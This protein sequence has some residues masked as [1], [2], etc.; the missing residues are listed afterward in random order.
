MH[1]LFYSFKNFLNEYFPFEV[2]KLPIQT[3]LGCPHRNNKT[4]EGGCIYC[5]EPAFSNLSDSMPSIKEQI[6][7][8]LD[9]EQKRNYQGKFMAYFQTGTN[10]Y[11]DIHQLESYYKTIESYDSIV[12]LAVSTRPDC[13]SKDILQLLSDQAQKKM[14]WL[15]L[16]MQSAHDKTLRFINRGHDFKCFQQAVNETKKYPDILICSH[17]ILGLPGE[18]KSEMLQTIKQFNKLQLKGIKLHHLQIVKNTIMEKMYKKGKIEV[19]AKQDYMALLMDVISNLSPDVV[20]QRL[21][22]ET[23]LEYLIAPRWLTP[24]VKLIQEF[25][26]Q[27]IAAGLYQGSYYHTQ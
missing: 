13:I 7:A 2:R 9:K 26:K 5:Y 23:Q 20:V 16:G 11:A 8:V 12:A 4:G 25:E 18:S 22:G 24:K 15:E 21:F 3:H 17:I 14:V 27:M 6:E 10:T 1:Q 19:L